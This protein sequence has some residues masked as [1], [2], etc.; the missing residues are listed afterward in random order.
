[1]LG[2][3][4]DLACSAPHMARGGLPEEAAPATRVWNYWTFTLFLGDQ[5]LRTPVFRKSAA[6][7]A[8]NV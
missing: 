5:P 1:M 7:Y 4:P 2:G 8:R 6:T 3:P